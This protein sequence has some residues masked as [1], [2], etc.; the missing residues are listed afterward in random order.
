MS[1]AVLC[2]NAELLAMKRRARVWKIIKNILF[3]FSGS[4]VSLI[5]LFPLIYMVVTSGKTE[6]SFV[7]AA[8]TIKMFLPDFSNLDVLFDNYKKI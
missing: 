5:F 4:I 7:A 6:S 3:Y 1:E 2:A 8:G